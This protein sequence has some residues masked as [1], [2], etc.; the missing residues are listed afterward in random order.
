MPPDRR[1]S[2]PPPFFAPALA[3][4]TDRIVFT[5]R[6]DVVAAKA[7]DWSV[8]PERLLEQTGEANEQVHT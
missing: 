6:I 5:D 8:P 1:P 7:Q 3:A 4:A 2:S